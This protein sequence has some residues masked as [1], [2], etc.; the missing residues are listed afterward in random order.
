MKNQ[1]NIQ[2]LKGM[3]SLIIWIQMSDFGKMDNMTASQKL[4]KDLMF[5]P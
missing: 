3:I 2:L 4:S 1:S 5:A